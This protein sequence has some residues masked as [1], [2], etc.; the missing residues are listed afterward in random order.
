MDLFHLFW[1]STPVKKSASLFSKCC[2]ICL[3]PENRCGPGGIVFGRVVKLGW[4]SSVLLNKLR[5]LSSLKTRVVE[6][7]SHYIPRT[8]SM[9]ESTCKRLIKNVPSSKVH[10]VSSG[11][12]SCF[13]RIPLGTLLLSSTSCSDVSTMSGTGFIRL[14]VEILLF[15]W[16][17]REY[18]GSLL[19]I[20]FHFTVPLFYR[21]KRFNKSCPAWAQ[22]IRYTGC[23]ASEWPELQSAGVWLSHIT[24]PKGSLLLRSAIF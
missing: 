21:M 19:Q 6:F 23:R 13:P 15:T 12:K 5:S 1:Q 11:Q 24:I 8:C 17:W 2:Y 14:F 7:L 9:D 4:Y 18:L 22:V 10:F 16:N 3:C 20:T